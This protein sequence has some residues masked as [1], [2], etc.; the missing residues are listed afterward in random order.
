MS[1]RGILFVCSAFPASRTF[2]TRRSDHKTLHRNHSYPRNRMITGRDWFCWK[3]RIVVLATHGVVAPWPNRAKKNNLGSLLATDS[4]FCSQ[5]PAYRDF[6]TASQATRSPLPCFL[7]SPGRHCGREGVSFKLVGGSTEVSHSGDCETWISGP[8]KPEYALQVMQYVV[9]GRQ[10]NLLV[11]IAM[12][13]C[14]NV[15]VRS[16]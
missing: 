9:D 8:L 5:Y 12:A 1:W 4:S 11:S 3:V 7:H 13:M 14:H 6:D 16:C 2:Q 10:L 15:P